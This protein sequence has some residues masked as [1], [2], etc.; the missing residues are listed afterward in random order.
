M[1]HAIGQFRFKYR[2]KDKDIVNKFE[3]KYGT[4]RN[5]Y[6]NHLKEAMNQCDYENYLPCI[7]VLNMHY[8]RHKAFSTI[9]NCKLRY[10]PEEIKAKIGLHAIQHFYPDEMM[11]LFEDP[12][13]Q[14]NTDLILLAQNIKK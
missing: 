14:T 4:F 1:H 5:C 2:E 8:E 12:Q 10:A 6:K 3:E 13:I 9:G 7:M 11:A